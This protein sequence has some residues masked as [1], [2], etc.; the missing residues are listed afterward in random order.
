MPQGTHAA[1]ELAF[2]Y[3]EQIKKWFD[4]SK[5]VVVLAVKT[6]HQL[7]QLHTR[8]KNDGIKHSVFNE[9]DRNNELTAIAILPGENV[10]KYCSSLP[11]AGSMRS[12]E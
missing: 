12:N 3:P 2:E 8:L 7:N 6:L 11:L 10:R 4:T 9:T 1:F 5:I